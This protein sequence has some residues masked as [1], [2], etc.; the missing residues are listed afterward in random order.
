MSLINVTDMGTKS[1]GHLPPKANLCY[2]I[3]RVNTNRYRDEFEEYYMLR[4]WGDRRVSRLRT[5][6]GQSAFH[7]YT[8]SF[9]EA[10]NVAMEAYKMLAEDSTY[11][12]VYM[13]REKIEVMVVKE[14]HKSP[15]FNIIDRDK[16]YLYIND[17]QATGIREIVKPYLEANLKGSGFQYAERSGFNGDVKPLSKHHNNKFVLV[18]IEEEHVV[19]TVVTPSSEEEFK[20]PKIEFKKCLKDDKE[21]TEYFLASEFVISKIWEAKLSEPITIE[22]KYTV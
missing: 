8:K 9:V 18:D 10:K 11:R 12:N 17:K 13:Q 7:F 14:Q 19:F 22:T 3:T 2:E 15:G 20:M 16:N 6:D 1:W 5:E 4:M 21:L